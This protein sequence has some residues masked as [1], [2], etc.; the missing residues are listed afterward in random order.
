MQLSASMGKLK[1]CN[2][3]FFHIHALRHILLSL[4]EEMANCMGCSLVQSRLD[5]IYSL[6]NGMSSA[7]FDK[8]QWIQNM[9]TRVVKLPKNISYFTYL[10]PTLLAFNLPMRPLQSV[11][12]H[13]QN[14]AV[15]RA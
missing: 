1:V 4:T 3:S 14:M 10:Q 7:N 2:A 12:A 11:S 6:Y 9:L 8:L 13:I 15:W 5:Y